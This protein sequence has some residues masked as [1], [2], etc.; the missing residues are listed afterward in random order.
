V[1][2][3]ATAAAVAVPD[4]ATCSEEIPLSV[5]TAKVP[6]ALPEA[7]GLNQTS[8]LLDWPAGRV[9]GMARPETENWLFDTFAWMMLAAMLPVFATETVCEILFPTMA[10]PKLTLEG[11][12]WITAS[13]WE[14]LP[15]A[16][17][18]PA[19]PLKNTAEELK[20][21]ALNKHTHPL[22]LVFTLISSSGLGQLFN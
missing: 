19:H 12:T 21:T 20:I 3:G 4:S 5:M 22:A 8:K 6:V 1:I 15:F 18:S 17:T 14:L 9:R 7:L 2:V 11:F 16:L 13:G 10:L